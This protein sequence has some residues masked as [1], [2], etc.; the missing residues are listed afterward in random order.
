MPKLTEDL[1]SAKTDLLEQWIEQNTS[2]GKLATFKTMR[3]EGD[4]EYVYAQKVDGLRFGQFGIHVERGH[5]N[6]THIKTGGL[7][8]T[9]T[10]E[11]AARRLVYC[12]SGLTDWKKIVWSDDP[13]YLKDQKLLHACRE[14]VTYCSGLP[15]DCSTLLE[16]IK[17]HVSSDV[18]EEVE[19]E[20]VAFGSGVKAPAKT[21][22]RQ[23]VPTSSENQGWGTAVT[24]AI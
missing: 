13:P 24:G 20:P 9:F 4:S 12:L 11:K 14:S 18:D 6:V 7:V 16:L 1:G 17:P 23:P 19:P 2:P 15:T 10:T 5:Y 21:R 3:L 22:Q 8:G